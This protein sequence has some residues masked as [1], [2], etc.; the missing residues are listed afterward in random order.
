MKKLLY[1][2]VLALLVVGCE[3][4]PDTKKFSINQN[5]KVR[6]EG[7]QHSSAMRVKAD[8]INPNYLSDLEIVKL[9][10]R[11]YGH[12]DDVWDKPYNLGWQGKDTISD[13][14]ALLRQASDVIADLTGYN[15]YGL[16][17]EFLDAYDLTISR[18]ANKASNPSADKE[19]L[20]TIAYI[21]NENIR[22]A[23]ELILVA[24]EE[25][26]TTAIYDVFNNAFKFHPIT[27]E[28]W[29]ALKA[30]NKQ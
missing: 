11:M 18:I 29:R 22:N 14:P 28:E 9:A 23:K 4:E 3:K 5:A 7:V 27:G 19:I 13:N 25:K 21:P 24:W 17:Y 1:L 20:D 16:V 6:I 8:S 12:N 26:D 30:E 15:E 2:L 10:D